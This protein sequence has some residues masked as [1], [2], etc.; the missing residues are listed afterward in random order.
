MDPPD[1]LKMDRMSV[2]RTVTDYLE[3]FGTFW[4]V[5]IVGLEGC[6]LLRE[7]QRNL[8]NGEIAIKKWIHVKPRPLPYEG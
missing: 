6:D 3:V 5:G 2:Q 7:K 4:P 8:A 1:K